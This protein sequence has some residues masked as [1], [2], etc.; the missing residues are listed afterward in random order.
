MQINTQSAKTLVQLPGEMVIDTVM[1]TYQ[2]L[3]EWRKGESPIQIDGDHV[4]NVDTAGV[5][6]LL[7]FVR[8]VKSDHKVVVWKT[9]S[10]ALKTAVELLGL[11]DELGL[12]A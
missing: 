3:D 10:D 9:P 12:A 4:S 5:Q 8:Q 1:D 11:T 7:A 6:I 2:R